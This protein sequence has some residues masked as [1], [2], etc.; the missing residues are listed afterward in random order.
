MN[1]FLFAKGKSFPKAG[2]ACSPSHEQ[3]V[4][5]PRSLFFRWRCRSL[6]ILCHRT[7]QVGNIR[8]IL[9]MGQ[10]KLKLNLN[11]EVAVP[12][13]WKVDIVG[14]EQSLR[15]VLYH[16]PC[17]LHYVWW[18][19]ILFDVWFCLMYDDDVWLWCMI[20]M[21][22]IYDAGWWWHMIDICK[23]LEPCWSHSWS[24]SVTLSIFIYRWS[25]G[26]APTTPVTLLVRT[27]PAAAVRRV[28]NVGGSEVALIRL[29]HS[30]MLMNS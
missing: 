9:G 21:M 10:L 11:V 26:A 1:V 22:M 28:L 13:K 29:M 18:C 15:S 25:Q 14:L 19:M 3:L 23:M 4:H 8:E 6:G 24:S 20:M 12:S 5:K 2:N 7:D 16:V 27:K 30:H 17:V